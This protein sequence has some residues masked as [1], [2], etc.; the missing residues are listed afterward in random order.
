MAADVDKLAA[1][2]DARRADRERYNKFV[3]LA[4]DGQD[5]MSFG[6]DLSGSLLAREALDLYGIASDPKWRDRLNESYPDARTKSP[7]TRDRLRDI[8]VAGR[9]RS[10]LV[11]RAQGRSRSPRT[12]QSSPIVPRAN[13][14]LLVRAGQAHRLAEG[15]TGCEGG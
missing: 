12:S 15:R 1:E 14:S 5:K 8:G 11:A 9:L 3:K 13:A 10:S 7:R 2:V 6:G 4:R